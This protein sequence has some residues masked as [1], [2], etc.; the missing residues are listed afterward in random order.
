MSKF[1]K[2]LLFANVAVVAVVVIVIVIV[3]IANAWTSPSGNPPT[4]SP[5]FGV[6]TG[7][8]QAFAQATC[9][10]GWLTANGSNVSRTTYSTL[11]AAIS[12]MYGVGDGSTT[13]TLPDYRGY[14]LRGW[15]NGST[16]DPDK[17]TRTNRGDGTVGD[18]VGTKQSY[19]V[20][21]HRHLLE[22][23]WTGTGEGLE[24]VAGYPAFTSVYSDYTG[25]NETRPINI[26]VLYCIKHTIY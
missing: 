18:Y 13:F 3:A 7:T 4:G 6:N 11:F 24:R 9:P 10:S 26:N 20:Q 23:G 25:G 12:T 16:V 1:N 2:I 14:F 15:A 17:A 5:S 22:R 8:V 21:S 19:Q